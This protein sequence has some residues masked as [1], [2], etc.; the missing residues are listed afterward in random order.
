MLSEQRKFQILNA[1]K[2][3]GSIT[4]SELKELLDASESTIRRDITELDREGK[5][6]K[7]FGGAISVNERESFEELSMQQKSVINLDEKKII[8]ELAATQ[9][10]PGDCVYIDSG[11]STGFL[12]DAVSEKEAVYVTNAVAHAKNLVLRGFK[13]FLIGGELKETTEAIIG[14]T[15]ILSLQKYQFSVGFFGTNG[16][17]LKRGFTTPDIREATMKKVAIQC[18]APQRRFIL[19]DHEKFGLISTVKFADIGDAIIVTDAKP[20]EKYANSLKLILPEQA[21]EPK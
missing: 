11:T 21:D 16:I 5:L 12:V 19:A 1:V 8:G 7:V 17:S 15:A 14:E 4:N 18:T 6:I 10:K 2:E 9:I 3:K 20:A 13:V